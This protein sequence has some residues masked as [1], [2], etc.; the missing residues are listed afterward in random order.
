MRQGW[1]LTFPVLFV[2]DFRETEDIFLLL[3]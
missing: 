1:S 2:H 3:K